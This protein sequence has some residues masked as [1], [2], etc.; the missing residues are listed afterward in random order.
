MNQ[1]D[2]LY[3]RDPNSHKGDYGHALLMAGS[4]GKMG[5]AILAA[6]ACLRSGVG[7]ITVRLPSRGVDIMQTALPEAMVSIDEGDRFSTALE[8]VGLKPYSALAVGPGLGTDEA[9]QCSLRLFLQ[10]RLDAGLQFP[11]VLDAD[12]I[13]IL[14]LHPEYLHLAAG[15][16]ITPH[17]GEYARLFADADPQAMADLHNIFIVKK[18]HRTVVFAPHR[19]PVVNCTGNPGMATAGSGDVLTGVILSLLSQ[20]VAYSR[21]HTD[22]AAASIQQVVAHAVKLHGLAGDLA[23]LSLAQSSVMASD[24][25]AFLPAAIRQCETGAS[26]LSVAP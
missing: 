15:A 12:A 14:A 25:I 1:F 8:R 10:A 4:Y 11:L 19:A 17:D 7:L 22:S 13:N 20:Y 2:F 3:N 5:A 16:V 26:D 6:N 18:A 21:R 24:I 23:A 9:T